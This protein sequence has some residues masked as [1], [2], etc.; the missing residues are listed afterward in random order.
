MQTPSRNERGASSVEYGLLVAGIAALLVVIVFA[1]GG[2]AKELFSD[3]CNEVRTGV[4]ANHAG[5]TA[6]CG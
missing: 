5:M 4:I 1:V 2:V 6:S 3:S